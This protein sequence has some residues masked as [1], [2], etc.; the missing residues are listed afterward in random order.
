MIAES[1]AGKAKT[2]SLRRISVSSTSPPRAAASAPS[3]TPMP[4]PMP[5][6]TSATAIEFRRRSS[7][8][9]GCRGRNGRCRTSAWPTAAAACRRRSAGDVVGRPDIGTSAIAAIATVMR[10][11][12]EERAA[13]M[14]WRRSSPRSRA[15]ARLVR[16]LRLSVPLSAGVTDCSNNRASVASR[17]V[18]DRAHRTSGGTS[19]PSSRP[20]INPATVSAAITSKVSTV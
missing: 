6:A 14:P 12:T 11:P 17:E 1:R 4:M 9:T 7:P 18:R 3:G 2:T 16:F 13:G 8:S 15:A 10:K 19:L 20:L 5:T